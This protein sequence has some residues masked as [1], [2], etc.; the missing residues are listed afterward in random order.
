MAAAARRVGILFG[1]LAGGSALIALLLGLALGSGLGRALSV[2]WYCVG[3][4]LLISGFFIGNRGPSRPQGEGWSAF[5]TKRWVR[6]ATPDEQRE[7]LSLSA[8][9][10][11]LGF[12]L[13]VLGAIAD[14]RYGVV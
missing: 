5:S 7:S 6:W 13:I 8:L 3:S 1:A 4:V 14:T 9:L 12:V 2:G 10:V 11:I